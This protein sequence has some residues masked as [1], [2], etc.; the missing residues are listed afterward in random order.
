MP[1]TQH[2]AQQP[3]PRIPWSA[4][5]DDASVNELLAV[6]RRQGGV[7][8]GDQLA[9]LLR[10]V[11][12][13]PVSTAARWI[14]HRDVIHFC[15]RGHSL[16]PMFQFDRTTMAPWPVVTAV[17]RELVPA[18]DDWE[19]ASWFGAANTWLSGSSPVEVLDHAPDEVVRA[20][21]AD[22]YIALG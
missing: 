4:T 19:V 12:A 21:R 22:R 15:W 18:F 9:T 2:F 11:G 17:L 7:A 16:V 20:A 8:S 14:V 1:T 13:Q 5:P 6:F 3:S 10:T